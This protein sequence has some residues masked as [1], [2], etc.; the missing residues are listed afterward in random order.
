MR[1]TEI[2]EEGMEQNIPG[3]SLFCG[4]N[5]GGSAVDNVNSRFMTWDGVLSCI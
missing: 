1:G 3:L 5:M 2:P 4:L